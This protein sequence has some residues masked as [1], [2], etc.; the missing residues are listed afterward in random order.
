MRHRLPTLISALSLL[1]LAALAVL[2]VRSYWRGDQVG[3]RSPGVRTS[4]G[5]QFA[6]ASFSGRLALSR[7]GWAGADP[8]DA[9]WFVGGRNPRPTYAMGWTFAG[10]GYRSVT[11]PT[12]WL[13]EF[14]V[15][16]WA[17]AAAL[18]AVPGVQVLSRRRRKRKPAAGLCGGCGYD[19]R[20]SKGRCPECGTAI[21]DSRPRTAG[22]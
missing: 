17:V 22:R 18:A 20:S 9:G 11:D 19:L 12:R 6:L 5:T 4:S 16:M 13:W 15:P 10:F 3:Y 2:W 14:R 1:L 21:P 7:S 8:S